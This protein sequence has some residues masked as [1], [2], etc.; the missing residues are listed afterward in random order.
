MRVRGV[1]EVDAAAVVPA[2]VKALLPQLVLRR[3]RVLAA[4]RAAEA[5]VVPAADVG[6]AAATANPQ[7]LQHRLRDIPMESFG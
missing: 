6:V 3:A 5:V 2:A 1:V 7:H 4:L